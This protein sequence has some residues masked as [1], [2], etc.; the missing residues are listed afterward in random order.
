MTT[1][2]FIVRHGETEWN[3]QGKIQGAADIPL[4][5]QGRYQASKLAQRLQNEPIA[6][7]YTS[8]QMRAYETAQ[9]A[10]KHHGELPFVKVP[11]LAE[12]G[13]GPH[14]GRIFTEVDAQID[15]D[16]MMDNE[17]RIQI[18]AETNLAA[19]RWVDEQLPGIVSKHVNQSILFS[20]HGGKKTFLLKTIFESHAETMEKLKTIRFGNCAL[21]IVDWYV[22]SGPILH[23]CNELD[24]LIELAE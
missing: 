17:Y 15:W 2:L 12:F 23:T 3:A 16:R 6:A 21:S 1:R 13:M 19:K 20:S 10:T 5:D 18:G 11:E 8:P 7:V 22:D 14:E 9:I 24:H 4:N